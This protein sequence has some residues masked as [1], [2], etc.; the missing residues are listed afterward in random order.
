MVGTT[1]EDLI[2]LFTSLPLALQPGLERWVDTG[3]NILKIL[4]WTMLYLPGSRKNWRLSSKCRRHLLL[5]DIR[6]MEMKTDLVEE[7]GECP[8]TQLM[9]YAQV[10]WLEAV[11]VFGRMICYLAVDMPTWVWSEA[12]SRPDKYKDF[13]PNEYVSDPMF[14]STIRPK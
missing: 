14:S 4:R 8:H 6:L 13:C 9:W 7:E 1:W 11:I 2:V 5:C 3:P 10:F 12:T